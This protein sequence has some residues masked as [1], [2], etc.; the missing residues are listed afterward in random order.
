[1]Q[2]DAMEKY[3]DKIAGHRRNRQ[4]AV[5]KKDISLAKRRNTITLPAANA[6]AGGIYLVT[7]NG[8]GRAATLKLL[9]VE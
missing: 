8:S 7:I 9:K 6:W 2:I 5:A 4:T 3:G 1:M